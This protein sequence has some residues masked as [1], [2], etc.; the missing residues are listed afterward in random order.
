MIDLLARDLV[1]NGYDLQMAQV[2]NFFSFKDEKN[3]FF[4][5]S[6]AAKLLNGY[7]ICINRKHE[8]QT[9]QKS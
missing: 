2:N 5:T 6:I 9:I 7:I 8:Q 4:V 3:F 1:E